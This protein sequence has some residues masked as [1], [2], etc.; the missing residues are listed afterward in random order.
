LAGAA[1]A[2]GVAAD[3][4]W[5]CVTLPDCWPTDAP[6]PKR[7]AH[8]VPPPNARDRTNTTD[9]NLMTIS[10][11]N[12]PWAITPT[13]ARHSALGSHVQGHH[14]PGEVVYVHMAKASRFHQ[15]FQL[16]LRRV[17]ANGLGQVPVAGFVVGNHSA[18][19]G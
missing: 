1:A 14:T 4:G 17:H 15:G 5:V 13:H 2:A 3:P 16:F 19:L 9:S 7:L 18:E 8:T 12:K 11:K 10:Q 6:P